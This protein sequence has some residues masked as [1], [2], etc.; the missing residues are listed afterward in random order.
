MVFVGL[1][2]IPG[3]DLGAVGT[4]GAECGVDVY[5]WHC[6]VVFNGVGFYKFWEDVP[7]SKSCF[8]VV[9]VGF[10]VKK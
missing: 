1:E 5:G 10:V 6:G 2:Y 8:L 7:W 9:Y 4:V 3:A